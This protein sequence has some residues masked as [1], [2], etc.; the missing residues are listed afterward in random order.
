MKIEDMRT[1]LIIEKLCDLLK[2]K[3]EFINSLEESDFIELAEDIG[4]SVSE[5][6]SK[7]EFLR[8]F[9]YNSADKN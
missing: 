8:E 2:E 7:A 6:I 9:P 5:E 3:V 1:I 4:Y